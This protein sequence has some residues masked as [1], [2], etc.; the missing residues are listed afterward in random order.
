MKELEKIMMEEWGEVRERFHYPQLPNPK[1]TDDV[2]NGCFNFEDLTTKISPKYV[3][4]LEGRGVDAR[5]AFD[6]T[7]SHEI[8]HFE[9]F[10][11]S[12]LGILRLHKSALEV[13]DAQK[14]QHLV[15]EFI[16]VQNNSD[17]KLNLDHPKTAEIQKHL[18][19]KDSPFGQSKMSN[20]I[21]GL[22]Q[23]M[24]KVDLGV[25]LSQEE[26]AIV[27]RLSKLDYTD[28]K[29]E[30]NT[31]KQFC[32]ILKDYADDSDNNG[33]GFYAMFSDNQIR[34]GIR[35]FSQ[36]C[37]NAAEFEQ[38][39]KAVLESA[40]TGDKPKKNYGSKD[41]KNNQALHATGAGT[42]RAVLKE[43]PDFYTALA[44]NY[45]IPIKRK[46]LENS[47]SLYPHSHGEFSI[48]DTMS[49][50]DPFSSE[51]IMPGV[52][53]KWIRKES[54][55]HGNQ[56]GIPDSI[57]VIDNS[58]SMPDPTGA[59]SIP[60]L[61]ATVI[62][63]AYLYNGASVA[64]YSFGGAD[65]LYGPSK[66]KSSVHRSI[67]AYTAGGT[68]FN[69]SYLLNLLSKSDKSFDVSIVSDMDISNMDA[70]VQAVLSIPKVH[71]VH[72]IYTNPLQKGI[73][74]S[75]YQKFSSY[76]NI[77]FL[78]LTSKDEISKISMGE[79]RKSIR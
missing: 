19:S 2:P 66:D 12:F 29:K 62:S 46:P 24:W 48:S 34:D 25:K 58:G 45:S 75:L 20:L 35:Q 21:N 72:L 56:Q 38:A 52:T 67:R 71:R 9:S 16:E 74:D 63:N 42:D 28:K 15:R 6:E 47:G 17:L 79:L 14:A 41:E 26:K 76:E 31:A 53:K 78:P 68:V 5:D 4:W 49:D 57:I 30:R 69:P 55:T 3:S 39:V 32:R 73:V 8:N 43:V 44:N 22:Y 23:E 64:V 1:L 7:F 77:A 36:E 40:Q 50:L 65:S 70:F 60:V 13:V 61:G 33:C 54:E 10:P 11:G 27:G 59:V 37:S 51:G 18:A